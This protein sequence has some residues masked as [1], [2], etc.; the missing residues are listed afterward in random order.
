M[1]R[2]ATGLHGAFDSDPEIELHTLVQRSSWRWIVP[3]TYLFEFSL[4]LR[5]PRVV[6]REHIDVVLF[7]SMTTAMATAVT[8]KRLHAAGARLATI[9]HGMDVTTPVP[10][11]QAFVRGMFR[12]LDIVFPVSCAT[13]EACVERGL[14]RSRMQVVPNGIDLDHFEALSELMAPFTTR[15]TGATASLPRD[16][17]LLLSVGRHIKRKGFA[18]F[19]ERVL[20]NLPQ[21][22]HYWMVGTG[23]ES[24]TVERAAARAG[25]SDRV[26][27]LGTV[28]EEEL[29][30]LYRNADLF[31]MPNVRVPGDME[32]FGVVM[33]EAGLR[34]L[35]TVAA[36]LEGIGDVIR[37]NENGFLCPSGDAESFTRKILEVKGDRELL[38]R[39]GRRAP[40]FVRGSFS[41]E[42]VGRKYIESLQRVC[43]RRRLVPEAVAL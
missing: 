29:H 31:V 3:R 39:V 40:D 4:P 34:G 24:E 12:D 8:A 38:N 20:P 23:P 26:R 6:R 13:G 17:F 5:L 2:V 11:F 43:G 22:V 32:G 15:G 35:P 42:V 7:T 33:L 41:W 25:V 30:Q 14:P 28:S 21:D 19:V 10:I 37:E 16:S 1:Q 9:A 27:L 36:D 18:W